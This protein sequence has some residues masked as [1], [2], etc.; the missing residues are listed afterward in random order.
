MLPKYSGEE[1][2]ARILAWCDR[3]E[4]SERQVLEKLSSWSIP[5][6]EKNAAL[7]RLKK[8]KAVDDER[9]AEAF[10]TDYLRFRKWGKQKIRQAL[11]KAGVS[12][13]IIDQVLRELD[14][15]DYEDALQSA[16][17][18]AMLRGHSLN[19]HRSKMK[20]ARHLAGKGFES[21]AIFKALDRQNQG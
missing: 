11:Y 21:D 12:G 2:F 18:N 4:R 6:A 19:D 20:L 1:L 14:E 3:R 13:D 7:H 15:T 10:S 5:E 17:D 8:I 16:I 9:F